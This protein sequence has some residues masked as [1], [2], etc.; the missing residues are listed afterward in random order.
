MSEREDYSNPNQ[1]DQGR[2]ELYDRKYDERVHR[3][4]GVMRK[5]SQM[6]ERDNVDPGYASCGD[7]QLLLLLAVCYDFA[8]DNELDDQLFLTL[9]A[10]LQSNLDDEEGEQLGRDLRALGAEWPE[11]LDEPEGN[12]KK[13]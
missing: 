4:S 5:L 3:L 8:L 1:L 7:T 2:K 13:D 10:F 6:M 12:D 11:F 9:Q